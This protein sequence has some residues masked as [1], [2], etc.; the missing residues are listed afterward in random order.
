MGND[1]SNNI[2][3]LM[4]IFLLCFIQSLLVIG[5][6]SISSIILLVFIS[7]LLYSLVLAALYV[8]TLVSLSHSCLDLL[9]PKFLLLVLILLSLLFTLLSVAGCNSQLIPSM[10]LY[11]SLFRRFFALSP[12]LSPPL[13][14]SRSL[15]QL[16]TFLSRGVERPKPPR[17]RF[18][19]LNTIHQIRY[20]SYFKRRSQSLHRGNMS[21]HLLSIECY[22]ANPML[23]LYVICVSRAQV[24]LLLVGVDEDVRTKQMQAN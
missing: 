23:L 8:S 19:I 10:F 12:P 20:V 17:F 14:I 24:V 13:S 3:K 11:F 22:I 15:S 2:I 9:V 5:S 6:F 21:V 1:G 7:F 18:P 16:C 4:L